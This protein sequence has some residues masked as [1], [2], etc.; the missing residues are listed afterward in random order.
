MTTL[1]VGNEFFTAAGALSEGATEWLQKYPEAATEIWALA[2]KEGRGLGDNVQMFMDRF[3]KITREGMYEGS[4]ALPFG[5]IGGGGRIAA[6][7]RAE[8]YAAQ[9]AGLQSQVEAT[10]LRQM[11]PDMMQE[12]LE[13][14]GVTGMEYIQGQTALELFQTDPAVYAEAFGLTQEQM[15][16]AIQYVRLNGPLTDLTPAEFASIAAMSTFRPVAKNDNVSFTTDNTALFSLPAGDVGFAGAIEYGRQ[17]YRIN[18]DPLAL[19]EDAYTGPRY[20]DGS[21]FLRPGM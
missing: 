19:T 18:P 8:R 3:G 21:G 7:Y 17:S 6:T 11:S 9:Q 15:V 16:A 13:Q 5:L 12:M 1:L 14:N 20:G 10:K 4:L 2:A